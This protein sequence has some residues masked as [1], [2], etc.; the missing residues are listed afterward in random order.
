MDVSTT[1]KVI[2]IKGTTIKEV[3]IVTQTEKNTEVVFTG[4]AN[5]TTIQIINVQ[6]TT[7]VKAEPIVPK[8]VVSGKPSVD[9]KPEIAKP[10]EDVVFA[11]PTIKRDFAEG[12]IKSFKYEETSF[13]SNYKVIIVNKKGETAVIELI[14][15]PG[16][17][18][19]VVNIQ[20]NPEVTAPKSDEPVKTEVTVAPKTGNKIVTTTD[21]QVI[22][23]DITLKYLT[24]NIVAKLPDL[25]QYV[26]I[27]ADTIT[28]GTSKEAS[29]IFAV[30]GKR[31]VQ[32]TVIFDTNT[33]KVDVVNT[34]EVKP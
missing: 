21:L 3:K 17:P 25:V 28:Y 27:K 5:G 23:S 9:I 11:N 4:I 15:E 18:I 29:I 8:P 30:E 13:V 32:V 31:L 16:Q 33:N 14:Q 24:Q 22:K 12:L 10:V 19:S 20:G 2:E 34:Q 6:E 7:P 1:T 26:P